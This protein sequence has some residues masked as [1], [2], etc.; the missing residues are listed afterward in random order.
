[1]KNILTPLLSQNNFT[2]SP[3][4]LDQIQTYLELIQ[5]WNQ[6]INLTAHRNIEEMIEKDILDCL[7]LNMYIKTYIKEV[8][9]ILDMGAGAGF[10]G[11][12]LKLMNSTWNVSFLEANRKKM[13]FI[14]EACRKLG[15]V[16]AGFPRPEPDD[17]NNDDKRKGVETSPLQQQFHQIR[18]ESNPPALHEKF[19]LIVSRATWSQRDFLKNAH[20]YVQNNGSIIWMAGPGEKLLT[21]DFYTQNNLLTH[22]EFNYTIEPKKYLRKFFF[23][24]KLFH[25][26]QA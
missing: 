2:L 25:V 4:L 22:N 14:R 11:I 1:M 18:A 8:N 15:I 12:I 16:G 23:F 5:E 24:Q 19:D 7:Y 9:N 10:Q 20:Y 21:G 6:H 26:E 3:S 13:N 17:D